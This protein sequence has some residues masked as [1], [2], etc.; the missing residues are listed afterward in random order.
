MNLKS[1]RIER[2]MKENVRI[3]SKTNLKTKLASVLLAGMMIAGMSTSTSLADNQQS[4]NR[5]QGYDRYSTSLAINNSIS[6]SGKVAI[7]AS[8][9]NYADSLSAQGLV[10][11]THGKLYLTEGNA[12]STKLIAQMKKDGIR[13]VIVVGGEKAISP[14]VYNILRN[15]FSSIS[16]ISGKSRYETNTQ[17][18]NEINKKSSPEFYVYVNGENYADSLSA[19]N[20]LK[21]SNARLVLIPNNGYVDGKAYD[22]DV[23]VGGLVKGNKSIP[24]IAGRD[25]YETSLKTLQAIKSTGNHLHVAS[26]RN[27]ADA[28]SL[29]TILMNK[30]KQD[31]LLIDG[32]TNL[33]LAQREAAHKYDNVTVYGGVKSITTSTANQLLR[34]YNPNPSQPSKPDKPSQSKY[35]KNSIVVNHDPK[36]ST[37]F[38]QSSIKSFEKEVYDTKMEKR[39]DTAFKEVRGQNAIIGPEYSRFDNQPNYIIGHNPGAMAD[40][41]ILKLGDIISITGNDGKTY[42]YKVIDKADFRKNNR[43][44]VSG[45][46]AMYAFHTGKIGD[47][48]G[49]SIFVHYCDGNLGQNQIFYAV[50]VK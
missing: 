19:V 3:K 46:S 33:T 35:E 23:I 15:N 22:K 11:S 8:G 25:R 5:I 39:N 41:A 30:D 20:I 13:Q 21:N 7:I 26:G 38:V 29:S 12:A 14:K 31:L 44:E 34:N 6:T 10:K 42:D 40:V 47:S 1:E 45:E 50:P 48:Y 28:L 9:E 37:T 32:R 2:K 24:K 27:Y 49:E 36:H 4:L 16:R 18:N 17:I 43:F